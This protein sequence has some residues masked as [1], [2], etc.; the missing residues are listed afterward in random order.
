MCLRL[1]LRSVCFWWT[2]YAGLV[3][4]LT[5]PQ[6]EPDLDS[7]GLPSYRSQH[8]SPCKSHSICR[9]GNARSSDKADVQFTRLVLLFSF[10]IQFRSRQ[11]SFDDTCT[12]SSGPQCAHYA[13]TS[14]PQQV[15]AFTGI[16]ASTLQA[17]QHWQ[18]MP[19]L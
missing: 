13:C 7:S 11:S 9:T 6:A 4:S 16:T 14:V 15:V 17:T 2:G 18:D 12:N 1:H 19:V 8:W 10:S 5:S 3:S